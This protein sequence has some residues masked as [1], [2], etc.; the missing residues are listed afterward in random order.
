MGAVGKSFRARSSST[1]PLG[2]RTI[3]FA[4]YLLLPLG[5]I[6]EALQQLR[7]AEK[8]DPLSPYGSS[9]LA[10]VL[11][12]AGRYDEA[13]QHCARKHRIAVECLGRARIGQGRIDEAIQILA[14]APNPR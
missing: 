10:Y 5:R 4:M 13:R 8:A 14:A 12:S 1:E 11:I 9:S 2:D 7:V 6:E 3:D